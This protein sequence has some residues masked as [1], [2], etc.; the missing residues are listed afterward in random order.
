MSATFTLVLSTGNAAFDGDPAP[1]VAR[2]LREVADDISEAGLSVG[3]VFR[4][5]DFNGNRV[6]FAALEDRP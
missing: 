6:G 3:K 2:I 4:L 5:W 1:E